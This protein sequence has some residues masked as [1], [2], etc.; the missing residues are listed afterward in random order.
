MRSIYPLSCVCVLAISLDSCCFNLAA[1]FRSAQLSHGPVRYT[2]W[3]PSVYRSS[4]LWLGKIFVENN[5]I[6]G[7]AAHDRDPAQ[8]QAC[9]NNIPRSLFRE[10]L[11][12]LIFIKRLETCSHAFNQAKKEG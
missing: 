7:E 9:F 8:R 1:S 4:M 12:S 6:P 3:G 10:L 2:V 5:V 11:A